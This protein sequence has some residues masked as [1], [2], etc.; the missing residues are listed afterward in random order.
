MRG[1]K[2]AKSPRLGQ[3]VR[4]S[5]PVV[6]RAGVECTAPWP[7]RIDAAQMKFPHTPWPHKTGWYLARPA[8]M[9]Q[10]AWL[11]SVGMLA[12]LAALRAATNAEFAF[13]TLALL[14]VM[15]MAWL[16]G[17]RGGLV[18]ALVA[19]AAWVVGDGASDGQHWASWVVWTN[20]V[21]RLCVYSLVAVLASQ[22]RL[23][24]ER[25]HD[26]ATADEL[27]GLAN[28]RHFFEAG[29][30]EVER[31]RRHSRALALVYL[32]L[33]NFKQLNDRQGHAVGDEAL[34]STAQALMGVARS[35]DL[36][37]RLGGDEFALLL[38]EVDS[39]A[40][41][42]AAQRVSSRVNTALAR[43]A[44]LSASL[45]V[46][47]FDD[48][49]PTMTDLLKAGDDLMYRA[50]AQRNGTVVVQTDP[51]PTKVREPEL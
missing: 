25:E 47:C 15:L 50:K 14:P 24:L 48:P 11:G 38:T 33:D 13:T 8:W 49:V 29:A 12:A 26:R 32:D 28:R 5:E 44:G 18:M 23:Q 43:Y 17:R 36:V 22:V 42:Q 37:A 45:G 10:L 35:T 34:Q 30:I 2:V 21:I 39:A 41:A 9:R 20:G 40:A 4:S 1:I 3:T 51:R 27:T 16:Y 46:A 19:S 7:K 31:A 6:G